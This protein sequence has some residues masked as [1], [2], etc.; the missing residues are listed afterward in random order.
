MRRRDIITGIAGAVALRGFAHAQE[1]GG[2]RRI[3]I[4]LAVAEADPVLP[5]FIAAAE[6][7][8]RS[9]GWKRENNLHIDIRVSGLDPKRLE[10]HARELVALKPEL[11]L[12]LSTPEIHAIRK[13]SATMPVVFAGSTDPVANGDVQSI[14]RPGGYTTGFTDYEPKADVRATIS[15]GNYRQ[16]LVEI[17]P[18]L[19]DCP[20]IP[21]SD[22]NRHGPP[23]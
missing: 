14:A 13:E 4:L 5:R 11:I 8:L 23:E 21:T 9:L 12:V 20:R 10:A 2:V 6:Q 18:T 16:A 3:A 19:T 7:G 22:G 15:R 1:R 17:G